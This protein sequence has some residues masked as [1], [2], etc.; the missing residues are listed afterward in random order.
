MVLFA[1]VDADYNFMFIEVG[2]PGSVNDASVWQVCK[3]YLKQQKMK[4]FCK[5]FVILTILGVCVMVY[6]WKLIIIL[7]PG[8]VDRL[9]LR[10]SAA[11]ADRGRHEKRRGRRTRG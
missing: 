3:N 2:Q 1:L 11:S 10:S 8:S 9:C 4:Y 5:V 6:E 7:F